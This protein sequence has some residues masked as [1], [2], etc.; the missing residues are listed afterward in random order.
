MLI[1]QTPILLSR[2]TYGPM[3]NFQYILGDPEAKKA[4]FIDPGWEGD[5]LAAH[6]SELGLTPVAIWLTHGHYDHVMGIPDILAI[7]PDLPIY[8]SDKEHP[9]YL[10]KLPYHSPFPSV[11][12]VGQIRASVFETPGHSPG[13]VCLHVGQM[14]FVGDTV[15][16]EGCG[17]TD[18]PGGDAQTLFRS[19]ETLRV[20][21]ADTRV[22][23]GHNYGYAS[24]VRMSE[25]L[26][27]NWVFSS[28]GK[29]HVFSV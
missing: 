4:V 5:R 16:V 17:R 13:S 27:N 20:F 2:Y 29:S 23:P 14:L 7:Y 1:T 15:F 22:F 3:D 10:G 8:I 25:L 11:L 26:T 12:S 9:L 6:M 28:P 21:P 19:L 24:D 18:L